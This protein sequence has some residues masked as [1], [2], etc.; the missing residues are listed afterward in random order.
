[1]LTL[2][3][4]HNLNRGAKLS[5]AMLLAVYFIL[6]ILQLQGYFEWR[7]PFFLLCVLTMMLVLQV[8][9]SRKGSTR[10]GWI[11]LVFGLLSWQMPVF[12]LRYATL[13]T[14]AFFV[15]EYFYGRLSFLVALTAI[16]ASPA[17]DN[18]TGVFT[19]PIRLWLSGMAGHLLHLVNPAIT[20]SGNLIL[21]GDSEFSVDT[22]CMGL[23]ML[24]TS[25]LCGVAL[26]ALYQRKL[27]RVLSPVLLLL[28][29]AFIVV[30][31]VV[32]NLF[33]IIL[34]VHLVLP[35]GT[36]AHEMGGIV[37]LLIYVV[38]PLLFLL[39]RLI[40]RLGK[41]RVQGPPAPVPY[42]Y[43]MGL[44]L[45]LAAGI[46]GIHCWAPSKAAA[47]AMPVKRLPGYTYTVL[48]DNVVK[49]TN[50]EALLYVK[51]VKGFYFTDHQPMICWKGSGFEFHKVK[52]ASI[53]GNKIFIAELKKDSSTLYTAW[54]YESGAHATNSQLEWR[55]DAGINGN[56]YALVNVTVEKQFLL[57]PTVT[58]LLNA[59][60]ILE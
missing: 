51:P 9:A 17:I 21:V 44:Q 18:I 48:P 26:I 55:W 57:V 27:Q 43:G 36:A 7:S 8:D 56:D 35:P 54:W 4:I 58:N 12:T 46:I 10:W 32:A 20:T 28:V 16:L 3:D 30:L 49:A 52:E 22:A 39:P 5:A 38:L 33:R 1:M 31:N 34:L 13:L 6:A 53:G 41:A 60:L 11:A 50:A 42:G 47:R 40:K 37:T 29:L 15:V 45:L 25:L 23:Q 2:L 19:F 14:A 59:H 24:L